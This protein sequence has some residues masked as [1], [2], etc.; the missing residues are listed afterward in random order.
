MIPISQINNIAAYLIFNQQIDNKDIIVICI[1]PDETIL[2]P[3]SIKQQKFYPK[4][5][6][7]IS[8]R[9]VTKK[10]FMA[11]SPSEEDSFIEMLLSEDGQ[12]VF[13]E[14]GGIPDDQEIPHTQTQLTV[15]ELKKGFNIWI[16]EIK[17]HLKTTQTEIILTGHKV[18][19]ILR[20]ELAKCLTN[21]VLFQS[22]EVS[23]GQNNDNR[24]YPT[25]SYNIN[26]QIYR[27]N[28]LPIKINLLK[29]GVEYNIYS[30]IH[31]IGFKIWAIVDKPFS[32]PLY[33]NDSLIANLPTIDLKE[34]NE[35]S[36]KKI[37]QYTLKQI[38]W[39]VFVNMYQELEIVIKDDFQVKRLKTI[40]LI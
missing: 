37:G 13:N 7:R 11:I 5:E 4:R 35:S 22:F 21:T 34:F 31:Y 23:G 39:G 24:L 32:P 20:G 1:S 27:E 33:K 2:N 15:H 8:N 36:E 14:A 25:L 16:T 29:R 10:I 30:Q 40:S 17:S 18:A 19:E 9:S 38:E 26:C 28:N 6:I 12:L 3:F